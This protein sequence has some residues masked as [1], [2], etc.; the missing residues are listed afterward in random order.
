MIG[1]SAG[2]DY[3]REDW[4]GVLGESDYTDI[5]G[6]S[7]RRL[8]GQARG[9]SPS[10][11]AATPPRPRSQLHGPAGGHAGRLKNKKRTGR[12]ICR[13][14]PPVPLRRATLFECVQAPFRRKGRTARNASPHS[15]M[16]D[17]PRGPAPRQNRAIEL[18]PSISILER[19]SPPCVISA[20]IY[21]RDRGCQG[22]PADGGTRL[23]FSGL[24]AALKLASRSLADTESGKYPVQAPPRRLSARHLARASRASRRSKAANSG[25]RPPE[26]PCSA[27]RSDAQERSRA[28]LC[29]RFVRTASER[30]APAARPRAAN[31]ASRSA[32]IPSP[33]LAETRRISRPAISPGRE[34]S[35]GPRADRTCSLPRRHCGPVRGDDVPVLRREGTL[36]SSRITTTSA[37]AGLPPD[38]VDALRSA[39]SRAARTPAVS[40][41]RTGTPRMLAPSSMK[42]RVVPAWGCHDGPVLAQQAVE[43]ARLACVGLARDHDR[44]PLPWP[45]GLRRS[46]PSAPRSA[47]RCLGAGPAARPSGTLRRRLPPGSRF[48]PPATRGRRGGRRAT[49]RSSATGRPGD[50]RERGRAP[51][52]TGP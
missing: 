41:Y 44:A 36:P 29:R 27:A 16:A 20:L 2:F 37:A 50:A 13:I 26:R 21:R 39:G 40:T 52:V 23:A 5:A 24:K 8:A 35:R 32:G 10:S 46:L 18:S 38:A 12:E 4:G 19:S 28:T 42:S 33:V 51:A 31:T 48:R 34:S 1:I 47:P 14:P 9:S 30:L 15:P 17:D 22:E 7:A 43:E 3:A 45:C 11:R 6:W 25:E 49:L